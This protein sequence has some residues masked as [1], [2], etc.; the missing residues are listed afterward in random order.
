MTW[1]ENLIQQKL[2]D[3]VDLTLRGAAADYAAYSA[4]VA[5]YRVLKE[6][7]DENAE[8]KKDIQ[9]DDFPDDDV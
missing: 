1:L 6:L 8:H 9:G 7:L 3:T 2:E 4:C 5:R